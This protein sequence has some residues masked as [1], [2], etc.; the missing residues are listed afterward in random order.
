MHAWKY[1]GNC[2]L[3]LSSLLGVID[4]RLRE[5]LVV[6]RSLARGVQPLCGFL[7]VLHAVLPSRSVWLFGF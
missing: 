1:V 7:A 2:R 4:P 6:L 5:Q 3:C